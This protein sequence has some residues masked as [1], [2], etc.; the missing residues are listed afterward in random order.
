[1]PRDRGTPPTAS[2][3]LIA[4]AGPFSTDAY[5][6]ALPAMQVSLHTSTATAQLTAT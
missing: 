4:A 6:S 3:A 1:M 5:V 2:L